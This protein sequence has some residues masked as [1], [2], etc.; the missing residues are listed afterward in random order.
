MLIGTI[1]GLIGSGGGVV[2]VNVLQGLNYSTQKAHA[3]SVLVMLPI[4]FVSAMVYLVKGYFNYKVGVCG[5]VGALIGGIIGAI[6]LKRLKEEII[7]N[8]FTALMLLSGIKMLF[9]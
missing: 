2:A 8:V 7:K 9:F 3:T 6:L 5:C 4:S 1:N